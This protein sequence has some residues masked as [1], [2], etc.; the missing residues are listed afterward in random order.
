MGSL[1]TST[2]K[3]RSMRNA[4][5][6]EFGLLLAAAAEYYGR[7]L[8]VSTIGMYWAGLEDMDLESVRAAMNAHIRDPKRGQFM[9]KIADIRGAVMARLEHD[10]RPGAE[11]AWAMLPRDEAGSVVWTAEMAAAFG[12]A[13]PLIEEGEETVAELV[14]ILEKGSI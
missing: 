8:S 9:P 2:T 4:D 14:R 7:E 5:R 3:G 6:K 1:T 12:V 13:L 10:G 11:E